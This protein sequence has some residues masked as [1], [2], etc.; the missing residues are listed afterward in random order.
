MRIA[1]LITA[2]LILAGICGYLYWTTTP[3]YVL[4]DAGMAIIRHDLTK[5]ESRVDIESAVDNL[6]EDLLVKPSKTTPGLTALQRETGRE[7]I[8]FAKLTLSNQ[9]CG[10]LRRAV[11]RA[12]ASS[13]NTGSKPSRNLPEAQFWNDTINLAFAINPA[14]AGNN[15]GMSDVQSFFKAAGKE[16]GREA[17]KLK[18][19]TYYRLTSCAQSQPKTIA[20]KLLGSHPRLLGSQAKQLIED[21][22]FTKDN[23]AGLESCTEKSVDE[24]GQLAYPRFK[25]HSPKAGKDVVIELELLRR[26]ALG[27]WKLSRISNIPEL[28]NGLGED[29]EYQVHSL[30]TCSLA[31]VTAQSVN[32]EVRGV[33]ERIKNSSGAQNLINKLKMRFR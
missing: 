27:D 30:M 4:Q 25:F 29:Y 2:A 22:G 12:S 24:V 32:D 1:L 10:T 13:P 26:S 5:F 16:L 15:P 9:L 17:G 20:G 3:L 28:M 8:A 19:E 14:I 21:Y 33:T 11:L 7:A 18:N 31:G 6:L 23:F